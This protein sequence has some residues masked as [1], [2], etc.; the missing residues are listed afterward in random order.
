VVQA[1]EALAI[2][3]TLSCW[4]VQ[5]M[6]L[7]DVPAVTAR[8]SLTRASKLAIISC[9]MAAPLS[10]SPQRFVDFT[11]RTLECRRGFLGQAPNLTGYHGKAHSVLPGASCSTAALSARR[12]V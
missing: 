10:A 1:F 12:F 3:E 11:R 5:V 9:L 4:V 7:R 8:M 2:S 6:A